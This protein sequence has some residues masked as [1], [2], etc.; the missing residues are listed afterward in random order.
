MIDT[1]SFFSYEHSTTGETEAGQT[2]TTPDNS[3]NCPGQSGTDRDNSRDKTHT[4]ADEHCDND[5]I[6]SLKKLFGF[7]SANELAT[8]SKPKPH[9][10]RD[11]VEQSSLHLLFGDSGCGKTF[12]AIDIACSIACEEITEWCGMPV[13]HGPVLYLCGEGQAGLKVRYNGWCQA[14]N[15]RPD[16]LNFSMF[17]AI[18]KIND[19]DSSDYNTDNLIKAIKATCGNPALVIVDTLARFFDGNENDTKDMNSF[20]NALTRISRETSAAILVISHT[21]HSQESK[22]RV[23]GSSALHGAC[24]VVI[25]A[26]RIGDNTLRL[27]QTKHK[28][29]SL[30]TGL[31]LNF[32][33]VTLS[34]A[35]NNEDGSPTTTLVPKISP[36]TS[37]RKANL[38]KLTQAQQ[39]ARRTFA[40]AAKKF[41]IFIND[42]DTRHKLVALDTKN[43]RDV[44]RSMSSSDNPDAQRKAFD[45]QR[46][47]LLEVDRI[48]SKRL[49]EGAEYYCLDI[50]NGGEDMLK[51]TI[52]AGIKAREGAASGG[53][54]GQESNAAA[55]H[56]LDETP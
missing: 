18:F 2:G 28:D 11:W 44:S 52:L 6:A 45:R 30:Q 42:E 50:E 1:S 49:I 8:P 4:E 48:L 23:R 16:T 40:E 38:K 53:A 47:Q 31:D 29:G 14:H 55:E 54:A 19:E 27:S 3:D 46:K 24:D 10:I 25:R 56:G 17:D 32:E 7:H 43:W 13:Q 33:K 37:Q 22:G 39:H 36:Y 35:W 51:I 34:T 21:G 12:T 41:G 5:E 20:V 9:L 26:E 15:I